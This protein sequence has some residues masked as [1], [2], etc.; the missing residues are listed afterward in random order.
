[1]ILIGLLLSIA[2]GILILI[3]LVRVILG[4]TVPDRVVAL[5]AINILTIALLVV[6]GI[7]SREIVY[8][9]VAIVYAM[10]SFVSVLYIS[11]YI[12]GHS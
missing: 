1:M 8:V 10:L 2:L 3:S 5:D 12:E 7:V 6:I 11:R 4:P 9:D